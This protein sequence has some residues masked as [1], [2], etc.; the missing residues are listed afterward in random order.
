MKIKT[1]RMSKCFLLVLFL[2][3]DAETERRRGRQSEFKGRQK[4]KKKQQQEQRDGARRAE[5]A[6][7]AIYWLLELG[8]FGEVRNNKWTS[9]RDEARRET[10]IA[11]T[12]SRK[13]NQI[14]VVA[15]AC[16][17][18]IQYL[19][20]LCDCARP[21]AVWASISIEQKSEVARRKMWG[22][23]YEERDE[24]DKGR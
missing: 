10:R 6:Y 22:C 15:E 3:D 16:G 24:R 12:R 7:G 13:Q 4:K 1:A 17:G 14:R 21:C 11:R 2:V 9:G 19:F 20:F 23:F 18:L 5:L 8:V